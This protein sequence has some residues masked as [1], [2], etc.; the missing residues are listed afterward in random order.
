MVAVSVVEAC[1]VR[2][3]DLVDLEILGAPRLVTGVVADRPG[4]IDIHFF[5]CYWKVRMHQ[6]VRVVTPAP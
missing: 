4:V 1:R 6:P 2:P 3:G 5:T